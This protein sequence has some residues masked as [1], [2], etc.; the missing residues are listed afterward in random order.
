MTPVWV[1][2]SGGHAKV[3]IATLRALGSFDV[4]GALDDDPGRWNAEVLGVPVRGGTSRGSINQLGV[5]CAIIAVGSN[6]ARVELAQRLSG[7][8]SWAIAVHPS[9]HLAPGVHIG[10]G[11]VVCAGAVVQSDSIVGRH[12]ILNTACSVDHDASIGDFVHVAP[13]AHLA[14][15]V[16]VGE[17]ALLGIGCSVLP[18][19][20][21]GD[22]AIVG[23]GG[24]VLRDVP[25]GVTAKGVPAR[26]NGS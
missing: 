19:C 2:G 4:A 9:A 20:T 24:V 22:W 16:R 7:Y 1:I 5:E 10:E 3:V 14:G 17:G 25:P 26:F 12:S 8:L 6:H 18:G 21:V 23:A 15:G 11:T 13:G